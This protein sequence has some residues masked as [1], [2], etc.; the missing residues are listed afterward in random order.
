MASTHD[1][2]PGA[3]RSQRPALTI[4][5]ELEGPIRLYTWFANESEG[6]RLADWLGSS[7][8]RRELICLALDLEHDT[9]AA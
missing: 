4:V 6:R 9:E 5:L 7:P 1:P 3:T 2:T 8:E